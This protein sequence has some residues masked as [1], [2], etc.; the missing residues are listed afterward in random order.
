MKT[1]LIDNMLHKRLKMYCVQN[2]LVLSKFVS[3]LI[4]KTLVGEELDNC[5]EYQKLLDEHIN[6]IENEISKDSDEYKNFQK[7]LNQ[8]WDKKEKE[9]YEESL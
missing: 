4:H 5:Q 3:N 8:Y 2:N 6:L 7:K 9:W 1:I